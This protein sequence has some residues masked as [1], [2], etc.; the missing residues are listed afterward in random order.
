[1]QHFGRL[2]L[3]AVL[4]AVSACNKSEVL[5]S[6]DL[7]TSGIYPEFSVLATGNGD[8]SVSVTL[9]VAGNDTNTTLE[10]TGDDK[11]VCT[12][13]GT[14][15]TLKLSGTAYKGTFD[16]DA[17]GTEFTFA[18]SRGDV[19]DDAP[20]SHVVLPDPFEL[21]GV[22]KT[23]EVS[24]AE[25]KVELTWDAS[26]ADDTSTWTIEGDCLFSKD[27]KVSTD[28]KLVLSGD[29]LDGTSIADA[30]DATDDEANCKATVCVDRK[31]VGHLDPAFAKEEG[32]EIRA[33]Q[34]RCIS[35]IST[36]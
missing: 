16:T 19:D 11:L 23:T 25:G 21:D 35:F 7:R 4:L 36:P 6:E 30:E 31:L 5:E 2:G 9:K 12:A 26:D 20:D 22:D 14:E 17:G 8:T 10:L 18:L 3:F 28:G 24:R 32:G 27:G 1:M 29:N 33:I 13:D 15:K 34:R